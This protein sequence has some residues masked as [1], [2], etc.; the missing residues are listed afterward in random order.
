MLD[1]VV[2]ISRGEMTTRWLGAGLA[3]AL[4]PGTVLCLEGDLGAGKT[5]F[6]RGLVKA[7]HGGEIVASPTFTL[8]NRYRVS[9]AQ[10]SAASTVVEV[11]HVDL[12]R[13]GG[14]IDQ[15]LLHSILEARDLG[16][17]IAVEWAAT[18]EP[19]LVPYL[20]ITLRLRPKDGVV[21]AG[22]AGTDADREG[23]RASEVPREIALEPVPPGWR[24]LPRIR[25]SWTR[26][27]QGA[28]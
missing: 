23:A 17:V 24:H 3:A 27:T 21:E 1:R 15:D 16:A 6:V 2:V 18:F 26:L 4:H 20:R 22:A 25:E 10:G 8:E 12:Y 19:W 13:P 7:L 11:V 9:P 5:T 14:R 28:R